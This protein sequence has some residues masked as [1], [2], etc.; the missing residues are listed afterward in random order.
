M[1]VLVLGAT[2]YIGGAVVERLAEQGHEVAVLVRP[3]AD[4]SRRVPGVADER[5]GDLADVAGLAAAITPDIDAIVV[6]A[7][8]GGDKEADLAAIGVLT[9]SGRKVVFTSGVWV[10]GATADGHEDSPADPIQLVAYRHEIEQLVIDGGGSVI[11]PGVVHGR[12]GGIPAMMRAQAAERGAGVYVTAGGEPHTWTFVHVDDLAELVV[13]VLERGG[14]RVYH[15]I[16]EEAVPVAE[17]AEAAARSAGV[18][19]QAEP[20]PQA[21]AAQVLGA[22][23]AEALALGQRISATRTRAELGWNPSRPGVVADLTEGSYV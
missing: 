10:L 3:A 23:F 8:L 20:W 7:Q 11:R 15:G 19:P 16:S 22:G 1:K 21:E 2:G 14:A 5:H 13:A 17:V 9:A 12:G 4:G 18:K 6:A